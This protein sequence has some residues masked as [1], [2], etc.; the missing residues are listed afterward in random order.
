MDITN[1]LPE[2][3]S[4]NGT[5]DGHGMVQHHP[6]VHIGSHDLLP[7]EDVLPSLV[8]IDEVFYLNTILHVVS[9]HVLDYRRYRGTIQEGSCTVRLPH[10]PR[11]ILSE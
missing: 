2:G 10:L 9:P 6:V 8:I 4:H 3:V 11:Q 1:W 7:I 5:G